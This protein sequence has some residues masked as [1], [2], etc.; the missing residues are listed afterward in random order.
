MGDRRQRD[1]PSPITSTAIPA[2]RRVLAEAPDV[3]PNPA[4]GVAGSPAIEGPRPSARCCVV[5]EA[6][7]NVEARSPSGTTAERMV[8]LL[9]G[10]LNS[11]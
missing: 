5:V 8:D 10:G 7:A 1:R 6:A 9:A 2:R 11:G 3:A 4:I